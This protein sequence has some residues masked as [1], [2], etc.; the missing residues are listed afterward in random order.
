MQT[1]TH[2]HS[3]RKTISGNQAYGYSQ[4]STG[5][6]YTPGLKIESIVKYIAEIF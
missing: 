3:F 6:G 5:C 1:H 2:T 4:P